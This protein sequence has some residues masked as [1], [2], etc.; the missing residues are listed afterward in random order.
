MNSAQI[1]KLKVELIKYKT[2][3]EKRAFV[4]GYLASLQSELE[5]QKRWKEEL[6]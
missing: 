3:S 5:I 1:E 6:V 4:D 2:I